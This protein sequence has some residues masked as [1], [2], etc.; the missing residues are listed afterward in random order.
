MTF[1][2]TSDEARR[3]W[4]AVIEKTFIDKAEVIIRRYNKPVSVVVNYDMWQ[5]LKKQRLELLERLSKEID[6]DKYYTQ[7][8]VDAGLEA[9][10]LV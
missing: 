5:M 8:E 7:E 1:T 4:R 3:D 9:R 10:G 6:E 2:M